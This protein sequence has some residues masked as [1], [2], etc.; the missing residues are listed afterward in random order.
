MTIICVISRKDFN[1]SLQGF[2]VVDIVMVGRSLVGRRLVVSRRLEVTSHRPVV[3]HI[4]DSKALL[5]AKH[6]ELEV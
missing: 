4:E 3:S 6:L 1:H 2:L 5:Q